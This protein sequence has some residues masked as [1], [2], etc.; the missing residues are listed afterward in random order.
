MADYVIL[1]T[2]LLLEVGTFTM[3]ELT[4][5]EAVE[6]IKIHSPK[7]FCGHQT[8]KVLGVE[9]S[10]SREACTGYVQALCVKPHGRLEFGKE[11]SVKEIEEVGYT[12][13]LISKVE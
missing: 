6:W 7:N 4:L 10:R 5:Q 3:K 1:S 9:P 2:P 8:V 12:I 11:Y 13:Y